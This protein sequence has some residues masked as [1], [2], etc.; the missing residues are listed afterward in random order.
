MVIRPS[1]PM[2]EPPQSA[3]AGRPRSLAVFMG[4]G[5]L[6]GLLIV[7]ASLVLL[8]SYIQAS[9]TDTDWRHLVRGRFAEVAAQIAVCYAILGGLTGMAGFV[10]VR[11][12]TTRQ[13]L[14]V[15]ASFWALL[16]ACGLLFSPGS[17]TR[18]P[19][20][21]R[22]PYGVSLGL[23][24]VAWL[25][26]A[27]ESRARAERFLIASLLLAAP[28]FLP[29]PRSLSRGGPYA[30][31]SVLILGLD[32]LSRDWTEALAN[33]LTQRTP[34]LRGHLRLLA[35]GVSPV[36]LTR[37]AWPGIIAGTNPVH[38]AGLDTLSR[39]DQ[40]RRL[41]EMDFNLTTFARA[42]GYTT[43]WVTDDAET[44]VFLAGE[45]FD[46]ARQDDV[47]WRTELRRTARYVLPLYDAYWGR[48]V[49]V[50]LASAPGGSSPWRLFGTVAAELRSPDGRP[51]IV[52]AHTV[53]LHGPLRPTLRE[54]ESVGSFLRSAPRD[55]NTPSYARPVWSRIPGRSP[56]SQ[57]AIYQRRADALIDETAGFIA[58]LDRE[59]FS[60]GSMIVV[61]SDHGEL[62]ASEPNLF[63]LHGT[64][65]EPHSVHVGMVVLLPR[66]WGPATDSLRVVRG[67]F[68]LYQVNELAR[69][70]IHQRRTSTCGGES[71]LDR[72]ACDD[73]LPWR[74]IPGRSVGRFELRIGLYGD[75]KR[76]PPATALASLRLWPDGRIGIQPSF[77]QRIAGVSDSGRSDGQRLVAVAPLES[78]QR[79]LSR[80]VGDSLLGEE[81]L[82]PPDEPQAVD[83]AMAGGSGRTR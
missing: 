54:F 10:A 20:V 19:G 79:L 72:V 40:V 12:R 30:N 57:Q 29:T 74:P 2:G 18:L 15:I 11:R 27:R 1:E 61:L 76:L 31:G 48:W 59:G 56:A 21:N 38:L 14:S 58:Q 35:N 73:S 62:F 33:R 26:L 43:S 49:G 6:L 70:F 22:L 39:A 55:I 81:I 8:R 32:N 37:F 51:R 41:R 9:V 82:P 24:L 47:G 34:T 52:A 36:P 7:A 16:A 46:R 4:A 80:Y 13:A 71:L 65:F 25:A 83:T 77:A 42:H 63:G 68:A 67:T 60:D 78:G 44:N 3:G 23:L 75:R 53:G 50:G 66:S 69:D 64:M 45:L 28:P 17:L 5:L